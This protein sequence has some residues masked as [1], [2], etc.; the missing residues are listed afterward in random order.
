[1]ARTVND[2]KLVV[3]GIACQ[4][5]HI[6]RLHH[7]VLAASNPEARY[8][9]PM[10]ETGQLLHRSPVCAAGQEAPGRSE[11]RQ[12][13][14]AETLQQGPVGQHPGPKMQHQGA[15]AAQLT[16]GA[17]LIDT[18]PRTDLNQPRELTCEVLRRMESDTAPQG[19]THQHDRLPLD[20]P[21][22]PIRHPAAV[23]G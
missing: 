9:E 6:A 16:K 2:L 18:A 20:F 21:L 5:A 23:A 12:Q 1:M 14:G 15:A 13:R 11:F 17:R 19:M 3:G 7:L 8:G 22:H 10:G 4:M